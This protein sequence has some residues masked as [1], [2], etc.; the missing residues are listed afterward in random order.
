[1]EDNSSTGLGGGGGM[2]QA[3]ML[4]IYCSAQ[5][6]RDH[7]QVMVRSASQGL[8]TPVLDDACKSDGLLLLLS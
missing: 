1:M 5:F 4:T 2:V 3:I 7:R 6:L 8:E